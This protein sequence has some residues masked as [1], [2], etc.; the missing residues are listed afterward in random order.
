M[1]ARPETVNLAAEI[2]QVQRHWEPRTVG[3][4]NGTALKVVRLR[5]DFERHAHADEDECFLVL[6]GALTIDFD[7]GPQTIRAGEFVVVPKGV[8]HAPHCSDEVELLLIEPASTVQYGDADATAVER[9]RDTAHV[10]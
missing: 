7:D 5:G 8:A 10:T 1:P 2:A 6:R 3:L 4:V 9:A